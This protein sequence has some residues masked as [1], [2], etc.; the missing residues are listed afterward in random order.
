[1]KRLYIDESDNRDK[2]LFYEVFKLKGRTIYHPNW[3]LRYQQRWILNVFKKHYPLSMSI[4]KCAEKHTNQKWLLKMD[5]QHFYESLPI[6]LILDI[7][8]KFSQKTTL[9]T[10]EEL[11]KYTIV[12]DILP[13]G[14]VTS[15]HLAN[16]CMKSIDKKIEQLCEKQDVEFSRYMDDL[17]FSANNKSDLQK[18]EIFVRELLAKYHLQINDDKVKYVSQNKK[19][20]IM[21]IL[22]NKKKTC[23]PKET[24]RKVRAVLHQYITGKITNENFVAGYL[25]YVFDVDKDYFKTLNKYYWAYKKKYPVEVSRI[26]IIGKIFNHNMRKL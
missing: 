25:S 13:T 18:T 1:M 11:K 23:L 8:T 15:A 6:E 19:Q 24:K 14:A 5:I 4:C 22:V 17:F 16:A 2:L 7:L 21:G 3:R 12:N 26:K 20:V 10:F 9:Y